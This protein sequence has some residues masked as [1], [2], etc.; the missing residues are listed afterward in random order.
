MT[1]FNIE[2]LKRSLNAPI[3]NR[4]APY[5]SQ[6]PDVLGQLLAGFRSPATRDTYRKAL[7]Y[8]FVTM[9]GVKPDRDSVLEILQP[10]RA[11][12]SPPPFRGGM[13]PTRHIYVPSCFA[14]SFDIT[15]NRFARN[16]ASSRNKITASPHTR[17]SF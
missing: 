10:G 8:F 11:G 4:F 15:N 13:N 3:A 7:N 6:D 17:H 5:D 12:E 14:L 9:T 16:I 1:N 2:R